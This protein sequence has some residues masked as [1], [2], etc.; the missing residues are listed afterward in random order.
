MICNCWEVWNSDSVRVL[1]TTLRSTSLCCTL[2][3]QSV[4]TLGKGMV[5]CGHHVWMSFSRVLGLLVLSRQE[6]WRVQWW[7]VSYFR[8]P[9]IL[10][11]K[12]YLLIVLPQMGRGHEPSWR[13]KFWKWFILWLNK[14]WSI[15]QDKFLKNK[16][17]NLLL[18][19]IW[20]LWL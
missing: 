4:E 12:E 9:T 3:G 11:S 18:R 15:F 6:S 16:S 10:I 14:L 5:S 8:V 13:P 17:K 19:F 2:R 1:W 7:S 20:L